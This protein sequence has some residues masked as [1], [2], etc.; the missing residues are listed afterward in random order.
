MSSE[1][2][3]DFRLELESVQGKCFRTEVRST[4]IFICGVH[5]D[6]WDG[7]E[8]A[9]ICP[10]QKGLLDGLRSILI[11]RLEANLRATPKLGPS[12]P[13]HNGQTSKASP[14]GLSWNSAN[15]LRV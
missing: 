1:T 10:Q 5:Q 2:V 7:Q 14:D 15:L 9:D 11:S 8:N 13:D 4:G 12:K 6:R 3:H